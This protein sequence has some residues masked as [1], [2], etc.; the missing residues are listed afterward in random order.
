MCVSSL[1]ATGAATENGQVDQ[2]G[3]RAVYSC[4]AELVAPLARVGGPVTQ[5]LSS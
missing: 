2:G 5:D 1:S 3:T 4:L